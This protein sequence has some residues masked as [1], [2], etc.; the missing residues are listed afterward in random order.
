MSRLPI[1][2]LDLAMATTADST[3]SALTNAVR[4]AQ[5][6]DELGFHRFWVAEHHNM[7][8]VA[9]TNPAVLIA[10]LASQTPRIRLGSGGVMLP[11]HA[12]L[13]IAEQF[14]LLEA[15][16]PDRIDLGIGRAPGSDQHTAAALRRTPDNRDAENFPMNLIDLMGLLGDERAEQG[17]WT[18]LSATPA[19]TS[20]PDIFLLGSSNFSA[21]LSGMLGLPFVFANHFDTGGTMQAVEIYRRS[22]RPSVILDEPYTMVTASVIVSETREE[23]EWQSGPGRIRKY[24]MRTGRRGPLISPEEAA[25]HPDL[26]AAK[27]MPSNSII[28]TAEDVLIGLESLTKATE[29]S[30]LMI[31]TSTFSIENRLKTLR[32]LTE[33]WSKDPVATEDSDLTP[34]EALA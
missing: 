21:E 13:V 33:V 12:P 24:G 25:D 3:S 1:S 29:A 5:C 26:P 4:L 32:L 10:H 11:N 7:D 31:S 27:A 28:G 18:H 20:Y 6:A 8:T 22:F 14:A 23:A 34:Q 16:H 30:E 9:S 2:V 19:A 17:A 15:L